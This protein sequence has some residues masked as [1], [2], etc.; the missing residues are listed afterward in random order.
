MPLARYFIFVGCALLALLF[1]LDST[2]PKAPV[3]DRTDTASSLPSIRI[4]SDRRWPERVV[5]DT[6]LPT[7]APVRTAIAQT[8]VSAPASAAVADESA[9]GRLLEAFAQLK[10]VDPATAEPSPQQK[11]KIAKRHVAPPKILVAQQ[12]RSGFFASNNW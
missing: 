10:T 3:A 9:K 1:I 2:L 11:R 12:P 4:N 5:I 8:I 6:S 7:I